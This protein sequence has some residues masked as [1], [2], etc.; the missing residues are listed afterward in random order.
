[1]SLLI[2]QNPYEFYHFFYVFEFLKNERNITNF[3]SFLLNG[4]FSEKNEIT[5]LDS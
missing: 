4:I 2:F 3:I 5:R 1:M